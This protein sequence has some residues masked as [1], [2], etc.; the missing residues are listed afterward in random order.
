MAFFW[1]RD[2]SLPASLPTEGSPDQ[3]A[4]T[5]FQI[6]RYC[7]TFAATF[8]AQCDAGTLFL[9]DSGGQPGVIATFLPALAN[10]KARWASI[11]AVPGVL[12]ELQRQFPNKNLTQTDLDNAISAINTM[13]AFLETNSL[14]DAQ[15][16]LLFR[17]ALLDGS[18]QTTAFTVTAG[19]QVATFRAA[20]VTFRDAFDAS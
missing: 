1:R 3:A 8:I 13:I 17:I 7:R 16:R 11:V 9:D 18:G 12:A 2:M 15:N 19:G 10:Y 14:K 20:L 6:A 5:I 4:S